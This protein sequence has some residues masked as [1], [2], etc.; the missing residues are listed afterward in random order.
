MQSIIIPENEKASRLTR[1]CVRGQRS[2]FGKNNTHGK[3]DLHTYTQTFNDRS[4]TPLWLHTTMFYSRTYNELG[5][6]YQFLAT[7]LPEVIQNG[8]GINHL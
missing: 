6:F 8:K 7:P 2:K 3:E 4:E 1:C 5:G